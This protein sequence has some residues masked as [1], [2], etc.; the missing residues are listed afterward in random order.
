[1]LSVQE[2]YYQPGIS[3][4]P[5]NVTSERFGIIYYQGKPEVTILGKY[6]LYMGWGESGI[7]CW[8]FRAPRSYYS[9]FT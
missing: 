1:M 7:N 5:D 6:I 4:N 9:C 3:S 8:G 2:L